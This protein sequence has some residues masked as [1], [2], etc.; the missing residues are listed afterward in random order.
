LLLFIFKIIWWDNFVAGLAP[1]GITILL[2]FGILFAVIGVLG[3]YTI[4]I[5]R[6]VSNRPIVV[7]EERVNFD[8]K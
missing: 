1:I 2:L 3:E 6:Y 5:Q 4:S 8:D 7:E